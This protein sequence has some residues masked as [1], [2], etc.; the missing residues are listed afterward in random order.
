MIVERT[1]APRTGVRT[2][3]IY[4]DVSI[5]LDRTPLSG[6]V[7]RVLDVDAVRR[8]I[9]SLVLTQV[10]ERKFSRIGSRV[11]SLLFE[12]MD[13]VT[14]GSLAEEIRQTIA[15]HEPRATAVVVSVRGDEARQAYFVS[16]VF[17]VATR[18]EP[19]RVD[20]VLRRVR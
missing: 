2:D 14:E 8:S 1:T 5:N 15:N 10:H 16:V 9:R 13:S 17:T 19:A 7:A 4:S 18:T 20:V 6:Q 11:R 12:P 3:A